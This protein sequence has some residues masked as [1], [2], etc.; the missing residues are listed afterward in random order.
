MN[1]NVRLGDVEFPFKKLLP[2]IRNGDRNYRLP[3]GAIFVIPEEWFALGEDLQRSK[4]TKTGFQVEKY[5]LDILSHIKSK[6]IK[7]HLNNIESIK[8]EKA[9]IHFKGELRPY[10]NDGLSWLMF[11]YR[12]GFGGILA[13]DMG[14]GK[15]VQTL[16]FLQKIKEEETTAQILLIAPTSLLFNWQNE[17]KSFTPNLKTYVHTGGNRLKRR[18]LFQEFDLIITSYG[19]IRNDHHLFNEEEFLCIVLD[20]SQYIKNQS[21]KS[22]Q[23]INKLSAKHRLCLTGTPIENSIKDLWSQMNFLNKGLLRSAR[24]FEQEFVRKIE[25]DQDKEKA[26]ELKKLVKPFVL[27]RTKQQVAKDLPPLTEKVVYCEMSEA[28]KNRYEEVK[29]EYRNELFQI[30]EQPKTENKLSILQGLTKLRLMADHPIL[31]DADYLGDSGK[32][33]SILE[34]IQ[35][36]VDEGHKVLVFSQ[37]V[38]YLTVLERDLKLR[39]IPHLL[40]TGSVP[41]LERKKR[42]KEFQENENFPVFLISLKAG[43]VGLNLTAADYVFI[44]DP[45][46]NPAT[47]AQARDRTHRIGQKNSVISYKFISTDTVE[48]KILKLQQRKKVIASD[49]IEIE[50]NIMKNLKTEELHKLFE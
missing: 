18:K 48:E 6:K 42:V 31:L 27:R 17:A 45:W 20:E 28:Q 24:A 40:L 14:L 38:S 19:L 26:S 5:Q 33:Q 16:S 3:N 9:S 21:A 22:T 2:N 43:G 12:N 46:W 39:S 47:E 23:L 50:E 34:H 1:I 35:T 4:R 49:V 7:E 37:F 41:S 8:E 25:K 10:Q 11:L 15:T 36:A 29:S 44:T 32:H 30:G 13:D